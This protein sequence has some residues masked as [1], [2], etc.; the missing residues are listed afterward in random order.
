MKMSI[1][2]FRKS[3]QD[4]GYYCKAQNINIVLLTMLFNILQAIW[5]QL[6]SSLSSMD[7]GTMFQLK[8]LINR[9]YVPNDPTKDMNAV[10][11]FLLLHAHVVS[12]AE[13]IISEISVESVTDLAKLIVVNYINYPEW[14][15][16]ISKKSDTTDL[17]HE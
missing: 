8:N 7:K 13:A 9:T 16:D 5:K 1:L 6:F 15:V 11:D 14:N 3:A 17:V 2:L 10:E 12:S 4:S